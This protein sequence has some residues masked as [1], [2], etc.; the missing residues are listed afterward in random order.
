MLI[1]DVN[2]KKPAK[3]RIDKLRLCEAFLYSN[4]KG[5]GRTREKKK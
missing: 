4:S 5:R 3:S 2:I 1:P